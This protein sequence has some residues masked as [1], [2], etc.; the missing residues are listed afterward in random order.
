[1]NKLIK[2]FIYIVSI[3]VAIIAAGCTDDIDPEITSLDVSRLFSPVDLEARI[4]NQTSVR[5]E[6]NAVK[7]AQHYNIEVHQNATENYSGTP[8]KTVTGVL[9]DQVPYII[10][11][12]AG[13]TTYSVRVQAVGEGIS[14]SKWTS[15]TFT[16]NPE[17]ILFP[18]NPE[19]ITA[20]GVTIRWPVGETATAIVLTPGNITRP[21]TASEIASGVAIITG[22]VSETSYTARLMNGTATRGT[23]SFTTLLDLG[24]AIAVYPEDNLTAILESASEGDVFALLPGTYSTQDIVISKTI[25]IKGARPTEKPVLLGTIFRLKDGA[26]LDLKDLILDGT[27]SANG[28]QTIIYDTA[29][30]GGTYGPLGMEDCVIRN[31]TKGTLYVNVAALIE[32]VTIKG[33]I[34]YNVECNGGDFIDFRN[35][36]AK[37]FNYTSNTAY[38]SAL[39]RDFFRMDA[40]GS[41]NFPGITSFINISN[42]TFNN[43]CN[44]SSRR[45]L[46]IRLALN[47]ITCNK[48]IFANTEGY[49]SNQAA[50]KI[51]G[52][53]N[54]NY[55]NAPNFT[56]STVSGAKNDTGTY[57]TLNPGFVNVAGGNFKVTNEVLIFNG[58]GDPRWLQ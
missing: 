23:V 28:N 58:I 35:G 13:E 37:T 4:V 45:I 26:G 27:G 6:W 2:R 44:G 40:G 43:V 31:Y 38:N 29:L 57:T 11:G 49:Y 1:M 9:Y 30:P 12:F 22:L 34:Y 41:T 3:T 50:T 21:V 54:N 39:A 53:S 48:N 36:M 14:D 42:N 24:G 56:G 32:S 46:Y 17:Q 55:F 16:T 7:K 51:V 19:E 33:C 8:F 15:T 52:M 18:L 25:A 20:T 10:P 47:E 5:L